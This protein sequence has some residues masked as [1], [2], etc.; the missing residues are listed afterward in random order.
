MRF[1]G[2]VLGF[3]GMRTTSQPDGKAVPLIFRHSTPKEFRT[4]ICDLCQ[5]EGERRPTA[6]TLVIT[7][8]ALMKDMELE[9]GLSDS[10][11]TALSQARRREGS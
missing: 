2:I 11:S 7:L 3:L 6:D 9:D 5:L 10:S 8:Q 1:N 4:V